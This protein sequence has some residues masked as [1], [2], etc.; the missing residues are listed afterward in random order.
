[1]K[2]SFK[3]YAL[4]WIIFFAAVN[5][6][7]FLIR[8]IIPGIE[9]VHDARFWIAWVFILIAFIGNLA[10]AYFAFKADNLQKMFY[11]LPLIRI[12]W[13][14]LIVMV[15][16]SCAIMLIPKCPAWIAAVVCIIILAFN[17][18]AVIKAAWA[19]DTVE[20]IDE[21]IKTQTSF[22]KNL[23]TDASVI[24]GHAKSDEVKADCKKVYEAARYSDP[25]SNEELSTIEADISVKMDEFSTAVNADDKDKTKEIADELVVLINDRNKKSKALK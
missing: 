21:K 23:T 19:A 18:I 11:N 3:Y 1:M 7:T 8:P 12:S 20:Q 2:K 14:G 25:M 13:I 4:I 10:C 24:L 16:A 22:I 17:V 15:A 6:V 5:A 9:V